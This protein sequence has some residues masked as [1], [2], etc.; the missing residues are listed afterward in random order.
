MKTNRPLSAHVILIFPLILILSWLLIDTHS[1]SAQSTGGTWSDFVNITNTPTSSTYPCIVADKSGNVHV[2]W[3]EAVG[4]VVRNLIYNNDGVLQF[5][6]RGNPINMLTETGNTLYYTRWDG[7]A[8]LEPLDIQV[9]PAGN[10]GYPASAVDSKGIIHTIWIQSVGAEASLLYSYVSVSDAMTAQAWS[11]PVVLSENLLYNYYPL[12]IGI[13]SADRIHVAFSKLGENP[14]VYIINSSDGGASWSEGQLVYRTYDPDGKIEGGVPI[15]LYA[16]DKQRLH[17]TWT[18][19]NQS[20]NGDAIYYAQSV[21]FGETWTDPIEIAVRQNGWY[22]VDWLSTGVIGDEIH[23][24]WE[25]GSIAFINEVIS[26]DGGKTWGETH[27]ILPNLVGENG[28]A[29]LVVDGSNRLRML[30]VKRGDGGTLSHGIWYTTW[31]NDTWDTPILL[32]TNISDLYST[33]AGMPQDELTAKLKGT[34]TGNGLRYQQ[35]T[36]VNGNELF[37]VVVNEWDGEIWSSHT[38]FPGITVPGQAY[39]TQQVHTT[40]D[41]TPTNHAITPMTNNISITTTTPINT[42][43][44]RHETNSTFYILISTIP[45]FLLLGLILVVKKLRQ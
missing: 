17:M 6:P 14:G 27:Q 20:G 30:V 12:D 2:F 25:G 8:W 33:A 42:T 16:D 40:A 28:F 38:T 24:I 43:P 19:F 4:G 13:D 15:R 44:P 11:K 22:E 45:V 26:V 35:S 36:I 31:T 29:N 7:K 21:D 37:V 23:L 10:I 9:S 3:T 34:F 41:P 32:G 18:R 5:D 39:P 1:V